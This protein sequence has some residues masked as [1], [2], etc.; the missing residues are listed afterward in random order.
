[1]HRWTL[2]L[3][4]FALA[5]ACKKGS[6]VSIQIAPSSATIPRNTTQSFSATVA[7]A[8][9]KSV[10][11]SVEENGGGW[12]DADPGASARA[13]VVVELDSSLPP[14]IDS[15]TASPADLAAGQAATLSWTLSG[16]PAVVSIDQGVGAVTGTSTS[17]KPAASTIYTLTASNPIGRAEKKAMVTVWNQ[18]PSVLAFSASPALISAG[19]P[20]TLSWTVADATTLEIDQ[21]VGPVSGTSIDVEPSQSVTY[22]LTARNPAGTSVFPC[23]VTVGPAL[24]PPQIALAAV[25]PEFILAG[26]SATLSWSVPLGTT[27]QIDHGIGASSGNSVAVSPAS[28][29]TWTLSATGPGGT[30]SAQVTLQVAAGSIVPPDDPGAA[31]VTFTLD[32]SQQARRISPFVYGYNAAT[33]E[34][35]PAGATLLRLGGSRWT[36]YNW[37]TNASNGGALSGFQN[38]KALS[39][40]STPGEAIRPSVA[41]AQAKPG[42]IVVTIP[43]QGWVAADST[44]AVDLSR[45]I[46][47]RFLHG[48]PRKG[49]AFSATPD[50]TD[51]T[52]SQDELAAFLDGAFPA[53]R[54]DPLR[55]IYFALDHEPDLWTSAHAEIQRTPTRYAE[56][57]PKIVATAAALKDAVPT[58]LVFGSV[59]YGFSGLLNLQVAPDASAHGYPDLWW[60]GWYLQ[61]IKSAGDLLGRRIVDVLDLHWRSEA[62]GGGIRITGS[63]TWPSVVSARVQAPR[64]LWDPGYVEDSYIT[65][66]ILS[67]SS[68]HAIHIIGRLRTFIDG[69]YPGTRISFS[70]YNHGGEG[71]ISGGIAEADVLGI[72]GREGVFAGAYLPLT[73]SPAFIHGAFHAFRDYDGAGAAFGNVSFQASSSDVSRASVYASIDAGHPERVVA[74]AINRST[75]AIDAAFKLS[76]TQLFTQAKGWQLTAASPIV[77]GAAV[78]QSIAAQMLAAK[79]SFHLSLP[80]MSVTTLEL[81]P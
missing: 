18:P 73:A 41:S 37:E 39:A 53:S 13:E 64:S 70:E 23:T 46:S 33:F 74:V 28:T 20:A 72:F 65:N 42:A 35:A 5:P 26:G 24:A 59:N 47:D 12:V 1:M 43:T 2:P 31:D 29:T 67:F 16:G 11:W 17:V 7:G 14:F 75:S 50:L 57:L 56:L 66:D 3:L 62:Q 45:P 15:F 49:G 61:Q 69:A 38:D 27:V 34:V 52:V 8:N 76:H 60:I 78:P 44:G 22:L 36:A 25:S 71:D 63:E 4:V 68:D 55:P 58:S 10:Y 81:L 80:A 32:S 48:V 19:Q 6:V 79:N 21:K 77:S 51:K 9:D 54:T 40:S 30:S